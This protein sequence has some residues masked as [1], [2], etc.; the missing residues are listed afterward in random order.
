MTPESCT[1]HEDTCGDLIRQPGRLSVAQD[2]A[3]KR[4]LENHSITTLEGTSVAKALFLAHDD[5]LLQFLEERALSPLEASRLLKY[6]AY[7]LKVNITGVGNKTSSGIHRCSLEILWLAFLRAET[8]LGRTP[9]ASNFASDSTV[10]TREHWKGRSVISTASSKCVNMQNHCNISEL[11]DPASRGK[12]VGFF[13]GYRLGFR[14]RKDIESLLESLKL[15]EWQHGPETRVAKWNELIKILAGSGYRCS[16][17]IAKVFGRINGCIWEQLRD[18]QDVNHQC[19]G[20]PRPPEDDSCDTSDSESDGS[21]RCSINIEDFLLDI[22]SSTWNVS[23][24]VF[25]PDDNPTLGAVASKVRPKLKP[26]SVK[27]R[28]SRTNSPVKRGE[29]THAPTI[30]NSTKQVTWHSDA[31]LRVR[32]RDSITRQKV[33]DRSVTPYPT[34]QHDTLG[35]PPAS[36]PVTPAV[37]PFTLSGDLRNKIASL[38]E[39]LNKTK[40]TLAPDTEL[41]AFM[42]ATTEGS[43]TLACV[44]QQLAR[45]EGMCDELTEGMA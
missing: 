14:N 36:L 27:D 22:K 39:S 42:A 3:G 16:P 12:A 24:Q 18:E 41:H 25:V 10:L 29:T 32:G 19:E 28:A 45:L 8:L 20:I 38:K 35:D 44:E 40:T 9:D 31:E 4:Y 26:M 37:V 11:C 5:I 13:E 7:R 30:S 17:E 2:D 15:Y 23:E 43:K 34:F 21:D 6:L 1:T 33:R